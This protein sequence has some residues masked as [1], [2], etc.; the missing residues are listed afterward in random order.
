[1]AL[2]LT[3][4]QTP[5][6]L[7]FSDDD[8]RTL[9]EIGS[10]LTSEM[11]THGVWTNECSSILKSN[12]K[13]LFL[14]DRFEYILGNAYGHHKCKIAL[15]P[16]MLICLHPDCLNL[17]AGPLVRIGHPFCL[18]NY[19]THLERHHD[20]MGDVMK[21][22]FGAVY[23]NLFLTSASLDEISISPHNLQTVTKGNKKNCHNNY[24]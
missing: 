1:M 7:N 8:K 21:D 10:L 9:H 15:N 13:L 3:S 23:K 24:I 22:R 16:M 6:A 2:K 12:P 20:R 17:A 5:K 18:K 11:N 14:Y 4:V 19:L